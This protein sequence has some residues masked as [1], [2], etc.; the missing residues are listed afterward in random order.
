MVTASLNVDGRISMGMDLILSSRF[1]VS[2]VRGLKSVEA[3]FCLLSVL[4]CAELASAFS[5][6]PIANR[7]SYPPQQWLSAAY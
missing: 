2:V 5:D 7:C 4:T 3:L 1:S 6:V